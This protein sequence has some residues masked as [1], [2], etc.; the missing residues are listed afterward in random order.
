MSYALAGTGHHLSPAVARSWL[1]VPADRG[2]DVAAA[3]ASPAD[4]VV[5]DLEDGVAAQKRAVARA[6][7]AHRLQSRRPVW[8][9]ISDT[10]TDDWRSIWTSWPPRHHAPWP[11]W[12][13]PKPRQAAGCKPPPPGSRT[14]PRSWR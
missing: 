11:V 7:V 14:A 1:L 6:A 5:L 10:T 8:V 3:E 12:Y 4:A 9:R 13:S 2:D